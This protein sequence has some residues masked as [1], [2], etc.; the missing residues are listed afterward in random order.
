M[1]GQI[2]AIL[3]VARTLTVFLVYLTHLDHEDMENLMMNKLQR[4]VD[5]SEYSKE[6]L[7]TLCWAIGS[8]SGAMTEDKEKRFLV[9]VIKELLGLCETRV[10]KD[11]KAVIA[12]CIMYIVGQYP[13]FLR[14]HWKFLKTVV[15]KLFEF[16]HEKH[17]G[18]QDMACDTFIK[19]A[20]ECKNHFVAQQVSEVQP[21]VDEIL[22]QMP[23]TI[24][25]LESHQI[26]TFY[27]AVGHMIYAQ[28]DPQIRAHLIQKLM[29]PPNQQW[30]LILGQAGHDQST[31]HNQQ[32]IEMLINI[33]K[34]NVYACSTIGNDFI[35]QLKVIYME[36][37]LLYKTMSEAIAGFIQSNGEAITTQ[38][39]IKAMRITK[40][41][42]L[43]LIGTWVPMSENPDEVQ[44]NFAPPL[45]DAVL[46]DYQDSIPAARD[47]EVLMTMAK[48]VNRLKEHI[49]GD[50]LRI[51]GHVFEPTLDMIKNDFEL[52][53][54][55][56]T[57]FYTLLLSITTHCFG[58]F[59]NL[60][61]VQLEMVVNA[62][63]WGFQHPIRNVAEISLKIMIELFAKVM[64]TP[65]QFAQGFFGKFFITV[66][67]AVFMVATD[68]LHYSELG[69]HSV[70][71]SRMFLLVEQN[72]VQVPLDPSGQSASNQ[73]FIT[74]HICEKLH[75]MFPDMAPAS[76]LQYVQGF[77][78]HD[79]DA[80]Q[81]KN[82]L[83]D[84]LIESKVG[85]P[86]WLC[87]T[88]PR[89]SACIL[90]L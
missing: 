21:F 6:T 1:H 73:E 67:E 47:A 3:I 39:V 76:V 66:I 8:I 88:L 71:L 28:H 46:Q 31:L 90:G 87:F 20:N 48:V 32:N 51:F 26:H 12:S 68:S 54:E 40:R 13:R 38:P 2:G 62:I 74:R 81:F 45:L 10:G 15:N 19:I 16:M 25:D 60:T 22:Q 56:R 82:W 70:I 61:E 36:M 14:A 11:H 83:R 7:E 79:E 77:F 29:Q 35:H 33:L 64:E 57:T 44:A 49:Q 86:A 34:A 69:Q 41:E 27:E 24:C 65:Q 50:V 80:N 75:L 9:I 18:V 30:T 85:L 43:K 53:P 59:A 55:H 17:E 84:F 52:F 37:L 23:T 58:A 72:H 89:G 63:I 4:Q 42:I 5:G 78:A